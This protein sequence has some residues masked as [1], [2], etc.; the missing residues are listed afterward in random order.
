MFLSSEHVS[1]LTFGIIINFYTSLIHV[2]DTL[3]LADNIEISIVLYCF[4]IY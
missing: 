4:L 3:H 1:R 2:T